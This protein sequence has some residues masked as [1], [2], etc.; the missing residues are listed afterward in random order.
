MNVSTVTN[1]TKC[2]R[3]DFVVTFVNL[4]EYI[5]LVTDSNV[6]CSPSFIQAAQ[7]D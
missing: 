4:H 1:R 7:Q 6:P 5:G 3:I 2:A